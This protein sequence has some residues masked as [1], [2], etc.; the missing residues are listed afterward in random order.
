MDVFAVDG[1]AG[2][3]SYGGGLERS[4]RIGFGETVEPYRFVLVGAGK[5]GVGEDEVIVACVF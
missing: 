4:G 2:N 5:G 1:N 3:G